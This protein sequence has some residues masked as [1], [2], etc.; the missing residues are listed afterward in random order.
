M[1][2]LHAER[3]CAQDENS[4]HSQIPDDAPLSRRER[5]RVA[6]AALRILEA[7][8]RAKL[9]QIALDARSLEAEAQ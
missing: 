1:R 8:Y 3:R 9:A 5:A 7:R 2:T 4:D 6:L